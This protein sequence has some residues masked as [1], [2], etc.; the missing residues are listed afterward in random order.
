MRL[1]HTQPASDIPYPCKSFTPYISSNCS[2]CCAVSGAVEQLISRR[3]GK[4]IAPFAAGGGLF[5]SML[6]TVGTPAANVMPYFSIHPKKR[7]WEKR[8]A[9]CIVSP[10]SRNGSRLSTCA[11]FQPKER[12]SKVRSSSVRPRN[13]SVDKPLSQYAQ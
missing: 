6:R 4:S 1:A 8:L 2:H 12:Y 9:M 11:E 3:V 5:S 13:S 10:F 7:L